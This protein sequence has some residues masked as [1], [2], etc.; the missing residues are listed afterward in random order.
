M[1]LLTIST[2]LALFL[3][4]ILSSAYAVPIDLSRARIATVVTDK[5]ALRRT[6]EILQQEV[7]KRS[8]IQLPVV[9]KFPAD[10]Q[11]FIGLVLEQNIAQLPISFRTLIQAMPESKNEGFKLVSIEKSNAVLIVG[12]DARDCFMVLGGCC[13]SWI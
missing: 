1:K 5:K 8:G 12:H 6:V 13:A 3:L 2:C 11:S 4:S 10:E 9:G 7:K